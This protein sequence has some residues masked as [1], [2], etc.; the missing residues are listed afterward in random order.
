[1][2]K[3]VLY[4][5]QDRR[6][7]SIYDRGSRACVGILETSAVD[8]NVQNVNV[9][10]EKKVPLPDWLTGTPSFVDVASKQVFRGSHAIQ[11]L[12]EKVAEREAP[13][14]A[15]EKPPQDEEVRG[16]TAPGQRFVV[17]EEESD[18]PITDLPSARAGGGT[19]RE[20]S[21]TESDLQAYMQQREAAMPAAKAQV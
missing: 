17:G 18:D 3:D 11:R 1:M 20:G 9:L 19:V 7:S 4:I 5:A 16:M 15:P 6:D 2:A 13:K 10:Q 14:G 8:V 21:V 12:R